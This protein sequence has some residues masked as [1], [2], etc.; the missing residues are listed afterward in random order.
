MNTLAA[1]FALALL[2]ALIGWFRARIV[3]A[4]PIERPIP[5]DPCD[6]VPVELQ[7]DVL[8]PRCGRRYSHTLNGWKLC[9][10]HYLSSFDDAHDVFDQ[11]A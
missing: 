2:I 8:S 6:T 9:T 1:I 7:C 10:R 4:Q 3:A 11:E 5:R